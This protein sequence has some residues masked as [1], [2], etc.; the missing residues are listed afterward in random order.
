MKKFIT[1]M[2]CSIQGQPPT[3]SLSDVEI[4]NN[5]TFITTCSNGHKSLTYFQQE[6][7]EVLFEFGCMALLDGYYREAVSSIAVAVERFHEYFIRIVSIQNKLPESDFENA[8][9]RMAAQSERQLGAFYYAYLNE[10][11]KA[12]SDFFHKQS[13]FRNK[14]THKGY[15]PTRQEAIEYAG[16]AYTYIIDILRTLKTEYQNSI[17]ILTSQHMMKA[18]AKA[19]EDTLPMA[20][21]AEGSILGLISGEKNWGTKPFSEELEQLKE[22]RAKY[23]L[24]CSLAQNQ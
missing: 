15:L 5:F 23:A 16:N 10:F 7:F 20:T 6:L 14:V 24:W 2:Q 22:K 1:C 11:E 17:R 21:Y 8:W 9:N 13:E 3:I 19:K 12:P 4:N 18:R